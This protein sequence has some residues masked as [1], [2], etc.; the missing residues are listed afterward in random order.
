MNRHIYI[1]GA[2]FLFLF[3][4]SLKAQTAVS[5]F[6][7]SDSLQVTEVVSDA[8]DMTD[9]LGHM[10]PA[11]ENSHMALRM[12]FNDSGAIDVYS[13][14]G[15]G[16]ELISYLWHPTEGQ[17]DTL[18]VGCDAYAVANT[19]GLGGVALW[20]GNGMV[21]LKATKGRTARVG[22][23]KKGSYAELVSY[24]VAYE[25]EMLDISV[26]IDVA[27]KT[28]EA[29][30]TVTELSGRKVSFVTGVNYHSGQKISTGE[31]YI[32]V[33]GPHKG[34]DIINPF[35]IGAGLFYPAKVF[36]TVEKT[37]DMVM[38]ISV[39]TDGF[40]TKI[41]SSSTKEAELNSA[42]RFEAYMTK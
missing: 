4:V 5:L 10:G 35:A 26:R 2:A 40:K 21:A 31:G 28:R 27:E 16:M 34:E 8:A 17:Q 13:K 32:S 24:G 42:K 29:Q 33:W 11:V 9:R 18:S 38:I 22:S 6:E 23:T 15:R 36:P 19:L 3:N 14:S 30:I 1:I 20:D 12:L 41:I 37:D 7:L 25:G 39:P